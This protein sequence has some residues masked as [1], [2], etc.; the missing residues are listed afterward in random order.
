MSGAKSKHRPWFYSDLAGWVG[1]RRWLS[2]VAG[3]LMEAAAGSAYAFG[4]Y[5][6]DLKTTLNLT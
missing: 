6:N 4:L 5:S 1:D 3:I 2:L